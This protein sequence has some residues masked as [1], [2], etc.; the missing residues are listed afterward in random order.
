M[1]GRVSTARAQLSYN[2]AIYTNFVNNVELTSRFDISY[3]VKEL[4]DLRSRKRLVF[5]IKDRNRFT[6]L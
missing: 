1:M 4:P 2:S 3:P 5:L 6:Y